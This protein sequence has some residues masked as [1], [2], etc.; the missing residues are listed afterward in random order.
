MLLQEHKN[1]LSTLRDAAVA[2]Q[3]TYD[4]FRFAFYDK[5]SGNQELG[6]FEYRYVD[7]Y[8]WACEQVTPVIDPGELIVGKCRTP[9]TQQ[10]EQRERTPRKIRQN[11]RGRSIHRRRP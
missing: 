2:P 9:L 6:A 1:R 5:L 11:R 4:Q 3:I 10:Q 7:A 8:K